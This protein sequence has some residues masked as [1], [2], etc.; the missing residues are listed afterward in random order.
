MTKKSQLIRGVT[1]NWLAMATSMLLGF[2]ISP[3]VVHHL[4]DSSY[5]VWTVIVSIASY[6]Q[7]LDLG[8]VLLRVVEH[9]GVQLVAPAV[10]AVL[11]ER[12]FLTLVGP[13]DVSVGGD[14]DVGDH[15]GRAFGHCC[16]LLVA[17]PS[18]PSP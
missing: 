5:G 18:S 15:P 12:A 3:F 10:A 4:G 1:M 14:R 7:L 8:L 17:T 9:P 11:A 6:M 13:G 2:F 16:V